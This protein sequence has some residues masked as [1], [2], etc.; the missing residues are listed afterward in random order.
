[1]ETGNP[2]IS[3]GKQITVAAA[4]GLTSAIKV[5]CMDVYGTASPRALNYGYLLT[6]G[7]KNL[8]LTLCGRRKGIS[9]KEKTIVECVIIGWAFGMNYDV[10]YI[11][12]GIQK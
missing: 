6:E 5:A 11:M 8:E 4:I 9:D 7:G 12:W 10:P 3:V 2:H 1:M